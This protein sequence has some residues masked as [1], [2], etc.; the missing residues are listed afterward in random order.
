LQEHWRLSRDTANA[1]LAVWRAASLLSED[2]IAEAAYRH[3]EAAVEGLACAAALAQWGGARLAEAARVLA[4]LVV[5][6]FPVSGDDL[7]GMGMPPGPVMG[8]ELKRLEQIWID[9][10]FALGKA[11]LLGLVRL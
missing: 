9:S 4:G 10:G 7:R 8:R 2:R 6:P 11:D 3:G 1:A 5:P